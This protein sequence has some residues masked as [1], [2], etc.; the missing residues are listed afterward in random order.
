MENTYLHA[1][2]NYLHAH[3][4]MGLFIT[5]LVACTESLPVIG[6]IIPGSV[7]MT[8]VG[9]LIGSA[10]MPL[11]ATILSAILGAFCGDFIGFWIGARYN[12]F[13]R[14]VWP[15]RNNPTWLIRGE[16]FFRKH[17]GKSVVF[18]R[19]I[20][21]VR[22][23]VPL[24]AGLMQMTTGRFLIAALPAAAIWALLYIF[25]GILIG[26]LSLEL[27]PKIATQFI[28][29]ILGIVAFGWLIFVMLHLC[30]K[31]IILLIDCFSLYCWNR[32]AHHQMQWLQSLLSYPGLAYPHRQLTLLFT[33]ILTALLFAAIYFEAIRHIG[34]AQ[35][36]ET[37]FILLRSLRTSAGET[38]MIWGTMLGEKWILLPVSA[39]ITIWLLWK[40][41]LWVAIHWFGLVF[42]SAGLIETFKHLY[43]SPRPPGLLYGEMTSSLPSGHATLSVVFYGFIAALIAQ[44]C[45]LAKRKIIYWI[46]SAIC[47]WVFFSRLYLGAHWLT[48]V[49]ASLFL[50]VTLILCTLLS[51][52][53][54]PH[55]ILPY[56]RFLFV[57]SIT[58]LIIWIGYTSFQ[59]R[60]L[61]QD[62]ALYWPKVTTNQVS[63][64]K[65][66][67][68][69]IPLYVISRTG[70]P[71]EVLNIQWIGDLNTIKQQL[72]SKGW[73]SH[74]T[75]NSIKGAFHRLS[76]QNNTQLPLLP[77]LYQ[78]RA[79]LL[80]MTKFDQNHQQLN[81]MLWESNVT[82]TDTQQLLWLGAL[83]Y[84]LP[85]PHKGLIPKPPT[86]IRSLYD[87]ALNILVGDIAG[88]SLK[89]VTIPASQQPPAMNS[90]P[91]NGKLLLIR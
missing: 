50:G 79:P 80:L 55:P 81:L 28:L 86:S 72:A 70:S 33:A 23:A 76:T 60:S 37:V 35:F 41:Q 87:Q 66:Q 47:L 51:Y 57:A 75:G 1:L 21:P 32:C 77:A 49:L 20:G 52:R 19:F 61:Q 53:S 13:L 82:L 69:A 54:R 84:Y 8:A 46:A 18:G 3:P 83:F 43:Y 17:G 78:N 26:A 91:W 15:L 56:K 31:K 90:L 7:T 64:W 36:N 14:S 11:T 12:Q 89:I 73:V 58:I 5:F 40:R 25:P 29:I 38:F 6:A 34:I 67:H 44:Y 4:H 10:I 74:S 85:H 30:Y 88:H 16:N 65:S 9:M 45:T 22:S 24:I 48:D 42:V 27:P 59:F 63:W 62:Y 2:V 71:K 39:I 68:Q